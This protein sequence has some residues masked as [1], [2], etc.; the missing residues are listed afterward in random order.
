[1]KKL[2]TA[3]LAL[4]VLSP[5]AAFAEDTL[6]VAYLAASS[7]NGYN[8]ATWKGV[9]AAAEEAGNVEV[10]LF[11]GQFSATVQFSQVEDI[12]ASDRFDAIVVAPNDT[13]GIAT[14]LQDAVDAG[15]LVGTTLFNVGPDLTLME[16]QVTGQTVAVAQEPSAG[17]TAQGEAVAAFCEDKD[18]CN[19]VVFVG[20]KIFP[21][22]NLR[23]E[24]QMAVLNQHENIKVVATGEGNYSPDTALT[25][26]MD[27]LQANSDIHAVLG[28]ADQHLTGIEIALE[29]AGLE[30]EPIFLIGGGLNQITVDA[31]RE[32]R[33]DATL[34]Q[35]PWSEGYLA[36]KA[37]IDVARGGETPFWIDPASATENP[38]IVTKEWLDANPD[39]TAEWEG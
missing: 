7:Q 4:T 17:A 8:D 14:V 15:I 10:E 9:Q 22:D 18:P 33:Y 31:I 16:P 39:F 27:I 30:V 20:Q 25:A 23:N 12:I 32:G 1:M 5:V 21:F 6:R 34:A 13:V 2:M 19:V 36:A 37:L 24:A 35:N 3:A 28:S 26:M 38:I 11:D 29:D